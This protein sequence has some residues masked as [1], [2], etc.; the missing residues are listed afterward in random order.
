MSDIGYRNFNNI[1]SGVTNANCRLRRNV[2]SFF[3]LIRY[4]VDIKSFLSVLT[5]QQN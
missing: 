3:Y 5:S 2:T 1:H 4:G